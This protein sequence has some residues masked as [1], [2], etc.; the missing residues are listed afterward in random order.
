MQEG[1]E[2]FTLNNNKLSQRT[3]I[4]DNSILG[5]IITSQNIQANSI[6]TVDYCV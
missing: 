3:S 5:F 2:Y 4:N 6:L 1:Y